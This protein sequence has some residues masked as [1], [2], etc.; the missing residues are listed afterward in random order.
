MALHDEL[1]AY[2]ARPD[3]FRREERGGRAHGVVREERAVF[4]HELLNGTN[5][6]R[7]SDEQITYSARGNV[8]GLQFFAVAGAVY[9]QCKAQGLGRELPTEW[10]LQDIR[11]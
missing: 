1:I 4:L 7:T 11:D 5:Q 9:E 3:Y 6:G 8:Q 10:F 2:A